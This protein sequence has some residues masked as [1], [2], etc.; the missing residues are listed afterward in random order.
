MA[1]PHYLQTAYRYAQLVAVADVQAI[2]DQLCVELVALGWTITAGGVGV[3]PTSFK[4][5]VV[6]GDA[7]NC[8]MSLT[9]TRTTA[10]RLKCQPYDSGGVAMNNSTPGN[11]VEVDIAAGVSTVNLF[12]G[13]NHICIDSS[14][15]PECFYAAIVDKY[16]EAKALVFPTFVT[17]NGPRRVDTGAL[18]NQGW[19]QTWQNSANDT[20]AYANTA[21]KMQAGDVASNT[22]WLA[23][24]SGKWRVIPVE[25]LG[26]GASLYAGAWHGRLPHCV[27]VDANNFLYGNE[28][29]V[30]VDVGVDATFRVVG[31]TFGALTGRFAFT[32]V[33]V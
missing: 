12:S 33:I 1:L 5:P 13:P 10:L 6:A 25:V 29:T 27:K 19:H 4:S 30:P 32:K 15:T 7:T 3:T 16:P 26:A 8:W 17:T 28:I 18:Y 31:L 24:I 22:L 21:A 23:T 20:T 11:A 14:L 9:L 2:I